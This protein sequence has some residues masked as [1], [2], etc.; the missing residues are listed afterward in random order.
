MFL[1]IFVLWLRKKPYLYLASLQLLYLDLCWGEKTL[2]PP[3]PFN[4]DIHTRW[5]VD[6]CLKKNTWYLFYLLVHWCTNC[7]SPF[8][9]P[10]HVQMP[11]LRYLIFAKKQRITF[12]DRGWAG[13]AKIFTLII[14]DFASHSARFL[15][16][17]ARTGSCRDGLK[18]LGT[19]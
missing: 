19:F 5:L 7:I 1:N 9:Y 4:L 16:L 18:L 15:G 12:F 13:W 10:V 2:S 3:P 6:R 11:S 8:M 14:L 17:S